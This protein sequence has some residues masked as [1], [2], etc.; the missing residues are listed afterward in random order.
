MI[1]IFHLFTKVMFLILVLTSFQLKAESDSTYAEKAYSEINKRNYLLAIE[2]FNKD[3]AIRE[4]AE[5]YSGR[6]I[7]NEQISNFSAAIED[8][9][10][11][12]PLLSSNRLIAEMYL[13]KGLCNYY[14]SELAAA[15]ENFEVAINQNFNL[16]G[17]RNKRSV[18]IIAEKKNNKLQNDT[19]K[20]SD[21]KDNFSVAFYVTAEFYYAEKKYQQCIL[22]CNK[23]LE[24]NPDYVNAYYLRAAS[25]YSIKDFISAIPDCD[26]CIELIPDSVFGYLLRAY[27]NYA[28]EDYNKSLADLNE[29]INL[30]STNPLIYEFRSKTYEKMKDFNMAIED[31]FKALELYK[32]KHTK[33]YLYSQIAFLYNRMQS[34]DLAIINCNKSIAIEKTAYAYSQ[35]ALAYE[36]ADEFDKAINDYSKAFNLF[37]NDTTKAKMLLYKGY[38]Y[39]DQKKYQEAEAQISKSIKLVETIPALLAKGR[40]NDLYLNNHK[41]AMIYYNRVLELDKD[42]STYSSYAHCYLGNKSLA[43]LT[44]NKIIEKSKNKEDQYYNMACIYAYSGM[45]NDAINYLKLAFNNGFM[46]VKKMLK[47]EDLNSIKE[48]DE[49][50][51]L[52]TKN[53]KRIK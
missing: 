50:K 13:N 25:N 8:Y 22:Y 43:F 26:K 14:M 15:K 47:D 51:E 31:E 40:L 27:S 34:S 52:V 41:I 32:N 38:C 4:S 10:R 45:T 17:S 1:K 44:Q 39:K 46:N 49:F 28:L 53:D 36:N 24:L 23:A 12:I 37:K 20:F 2:Y 7:A 9:N 30:N 29:A 19:T 5:S 16:R 11:A 35:R 18:D 42:S 6:A 33:R 3:I 21:L 48:T